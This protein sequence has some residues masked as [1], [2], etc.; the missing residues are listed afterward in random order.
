M[1]QGTVP[2]S[3]EEN[4]NWEHRGRFSRPKKLKRQQK[5]KLSKNAEQKT[6]LPTQ[7]GKRVSSLHTR[8]TRSSRKTKEAWCSS[9]NSSFSHALEAQSSVLKSCYNHV[10]ETRISQQTVPRFQFQYSAESPILQLDIHHLR[11]SAACGVNACEGYKMATSK[12]LPSLVHFVR[13]F[14]AWAFLVF[15]GKVTVLMILMVL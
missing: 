8:Q 1:G 5:P 14:A 9:N 10:N 13:G 12:F 7:I 2:P 15:L 6:V 4:S 3:H 11:G